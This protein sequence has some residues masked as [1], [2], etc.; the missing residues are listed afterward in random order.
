MR[1]HRWARTLNIIAKLLHAMAQRES[2]RQLS[3]RVEIDDAYLG[4]EHPGKRGR[5][6]PN[7]V[8]F[9]IGVSTARKGVRPE[10]HLLKPSLHNFH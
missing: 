10:W 6:S 2:R 9:V 5:S 4:G 1:V 7:K 8:T 3:G